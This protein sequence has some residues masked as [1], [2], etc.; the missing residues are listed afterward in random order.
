M[1]KTYAQQKQKATGQAIYKFH[2]SPRP[3]WQTDHAK[4]GKNLE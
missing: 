2:E 3:A 4:M 1:S